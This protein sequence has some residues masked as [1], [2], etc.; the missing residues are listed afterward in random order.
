[1]AANRPVHAH[2]EVANHV[3]LSAAGVQVEVVLQ[4]SDESVLGEPHF[5]VYLPALSAAYERIFLKKLDP[6]N[7]LRE[8]CFILCMFMSAVRVLKMRTGL[9]SLTAQSAAAPLTAITLD[10]FPPKAPPILGHLTCT[11]R[12]EARN[13]K[14][15]R[16]A[17]NFA[18]CSSYLVLLD[19]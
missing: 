3:V 12:R 11:C 5:V 1:M 4:S 2:E 17:R 7:Q 10:I 14:I 15:K 13:S 9:P 8:I 6:C 16:T 18:K 19:T